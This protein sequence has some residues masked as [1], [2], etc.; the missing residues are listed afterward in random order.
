[1][2]STSMR[3]VL[4]KVFCLTLFLGLAGSA[5]PTEST[6]ESVRSSDRL[7]AQVPA[8]LTLRQAASRRA[9]LLPIGAAIDTDALVLDK[10]YNA[11]TA[12]EFNSV[13]AE[14]AMKW[15]MLRP[16]APTP[17]SNSFDFTGADRLVNFAQRN[18]MQVRG[19]TLVWH[20]GLPGWM[21]SKQ[22][23]SA[24]LQALL[25]NHIQT[26]VGRYKGKIRA[27]DVVNEGVGDDAQLRKG[28]WLNTLGPGYIERA[29]RW[30]READPQAKLFYN[31]YGAEAIGPKSDAVYKLVA[32][33]K[34]R[35]VPIDGVGLQVHLSLVAL[36]DLQK[37]EANIKRLEALGLEVQI[38]EMDVA[39]VGDQS[40]RT[41]GTQAE[42]RQKQ[43]QVYRDWLDLCL[44]STRCTSF[45]VWGVADHRSWL[46]TSL[47]I[48]G[49]EPLVLDDKYRPKPAHAELVRR[50]QL[51]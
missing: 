2:R 31:D 34:R 11:R 1:M 35:G 25:K 22:W 28:V 21:T 14:N 49:A 38:T 47:K 40:G 46:R 37:V 27:W 33:L 19:H 29:F 20:E 41:C 3:S 39:C 26:V 50:L 12:Q 4:S 23:S 6:A 13:T 45:S 7:V 9:K 24:E 32:G 8:S 42:F 43:A 18:Q 10:V 36:P 30:A 15:W 44:R 48:A 51:Q 16:Q 17:M 5:V